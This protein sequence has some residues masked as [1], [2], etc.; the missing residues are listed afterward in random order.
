MGH[1]KYPTIL[2]AVTAVHTLAS[3][4]AEIERAFS[5]RGKTVTVWNS[6]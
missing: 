1:T 3:G 6:S 4:N 2:S 5:D